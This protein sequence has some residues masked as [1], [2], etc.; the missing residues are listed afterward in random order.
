[1]KGFLSV[2]KHALKE[3]GITNCY[4]MLNFFKNAEI[5]ET[6]NPVLETCYRLGPANIEN[7][8]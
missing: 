5:S 3:R 6:E 8:W 4:Q 1:M 7:K 2:A